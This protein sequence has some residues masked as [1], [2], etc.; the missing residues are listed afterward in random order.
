MP[1]GFLY[2][3]GSPIPWSYYDNV[4]EETIQSNIKPKKVPTF[5]EE[6]WIS[7]REWYAEKG[8]GVPINEANECLRDIAK[9]KADLVTYWESIK[10]AQKAQQVPPKRIS[11][12]DWKAYWDKK[13]AKGWVP[14]KLKGGTGGKGVT[15]GK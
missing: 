10:E 8:V 1:S 5:A 11:G 13:K 15:G 12:V 2:L 7:V 14:K 9:E 3:D 4:H 6:I